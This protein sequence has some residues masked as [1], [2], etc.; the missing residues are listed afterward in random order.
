GEV[1]VSDVAGG[2]DVSPVSV[3]SGGDVPGSDPPQ[4]SHSAIPGHSELHIG[5]P[6]PSVVVVD[7]C[8]PVSD[9]GPTRRGSTTVR[10]FEASA[11]GPPDGPPPAN[12]ATGRSVCPAIV[13]P[14][15]PRSSQ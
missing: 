5:P 8:W 3:P 13:R 4:P 6:S 1:A 10:S 14:S 7:R 15:S 2:D 9:R 12:R 11:R